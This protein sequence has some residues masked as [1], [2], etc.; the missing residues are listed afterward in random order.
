M[1][2]AVRALLCATAWHAKHALDSSNIRTQLQSL[3]NVE[4]HP[5]FSLQAGTMTDKSQ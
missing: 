5:L 4:G 1:G 3:A 2:C